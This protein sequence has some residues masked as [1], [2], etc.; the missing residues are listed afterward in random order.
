MVKDYN[1]NSTAPATV[2]GAES[3]DEEDPRTPT[4]VSSQGSQPYDNVPAD[5]VDVEGFTAIPEGA[6]PELNLQVGEHGSKCCTYNLTNLRPLVQAGIYDE[7]GE[8]RLQ[9]GR[10]TDNNMYYSTAIHGNYSITPADSNNPKFN[11]IVGQK[12]EG[13]KIFSI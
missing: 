1:A 7:L 10:A 4:S 9:F 6:L 3:E 11:A 2:V 12:Q 13:Q 8:D 5:F